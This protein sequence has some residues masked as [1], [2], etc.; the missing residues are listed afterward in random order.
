MDSFRFRG[1]T[2]IKE[3]NQ[4]YDDI[5]SIPHSW[6]VEFRDDAAWLFF[7]DSEEDKDVLISLIMQLSKLK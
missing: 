6:A 7:A 1:V 2:G 3:W 5:R 4:G